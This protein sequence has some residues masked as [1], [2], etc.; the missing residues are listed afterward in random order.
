MKDYHQSGLTHPNYPHHL[1]PHHP[2]P[3][4]LDHDDDLRNEV[5]DDL[6]FGSSNQ[7]NYRPYGPP[8][9]ALNR[10]LFKSTMNYPLSNRSI[11]SSS[12]MNYRNQMRNIPPGRGERP[13]RDLF[14]ENR[15][16]LRA[17]RHQTS[18]TSSASSSHQGISSRDGF[19]ESERR[20]IDSGNSRDGRYHH[21]SSL[22]GY[23]RNS[24]SSTRSGSD[25]NSN[26][27]NRDE[28][29]HHGSN[30]SYS[31]SSKSSHQ[32]RERDEDNHGTSYDNNNNDS[33]IKQEQTD[34]MDNS[35]SE[36]PLEG[37]SFSSVQSALSKITI[38]ESL[39]G[40]E[41][42]DLIIRLKKNKNSSTSKDYD[43]EFYVDKKKRHTDNT[44]ETENRENQNNGE[45]LSEEYLLDDI[46]N[47]EKYGIEGGDSHD[48]IS[49]EFGNGLMT[50][51]QNIHNLHTIVLDGFT[52]DLKQS[53]SNGLLQN[54]GLV[55][56]L[57]EDIFAACLEDYRELTPMNDY[58]NQ[59]F[60]DFDEPNDI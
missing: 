41:L 12:T 9:P 47:N 11:H 59:D 8:H 17:L 2:H 49:N 48:Y 22:E 43:D 20:K 16:R 40:P 25:K 53:F 35:G 58:N 3:H 15:E 27:Q 44:S 33:N 23:R 54:I 36:N 42:Y 34:T 4:H 52:D 29:Y 10:M 28:H 30:S 60:N 56:V 39:A 18:R 38:L 24:L 31:K 14:H 7:S 21:R 37:K 51:K 45:D 57:P 32:H 5:N 46:H 6:R 13:T 1:S 50:L 55:S 19:R 26:H